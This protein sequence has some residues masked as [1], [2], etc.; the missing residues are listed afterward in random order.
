MIVACTLP[1]AGLGLLG[2]RIADY[3]GRKRVLLIGLIGF[4]A[5]DG[6]AIDTP[7]PD[8]PTDTG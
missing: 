7:W 6:A 3:V 5:V 8:S 4:S 2:G 1:F